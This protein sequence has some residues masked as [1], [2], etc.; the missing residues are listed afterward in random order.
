MRSV[1]LVRRSS[2]EFVERVF[3]CAVGVM[4]TGCLAPTEATLSISSDSAL[5]S[6]SNNYANVQING[7]TLEAAGTFASARSTPRLGESK[8]RQPWSR[9]TGDAASFSSQVRATLG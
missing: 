9:T 8:M 6:A 1:R 2:R 7:G 4:T 5:G 3:V